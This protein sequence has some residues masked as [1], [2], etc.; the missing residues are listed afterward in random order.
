MGPTAVKRGIF[1]APFD[2]LARPQLLMELASR[3]EELG[4][5]GLF[6]WD[7]VRYR[8]PTRDVLDPWVDAERDSHCD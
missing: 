4:W 7:H 1:V 8:A 6:L 5:D 2:E 3:M